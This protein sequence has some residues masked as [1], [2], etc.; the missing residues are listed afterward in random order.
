MKNDFYKRFEDR[1]R[2][3]RET[4]KGRLRV[5]LPLVETLKTLMPVPSALDL[6]CGR[7]EWLE[8]LGEEGFEARGIDQDPQ[9]LLDAHDLGL[10][11][12]QGDALEHLRNLPEASV[13]LV[14]GFHIAEHLLFDDLLVLVEQAHRVLIPGGLLI[15]ETPNPENIA[16]GANSFY[17]DPTHTRPLP[18]ALLSFLPEFVG[19]ERGTIFRLNAREFPPET[20]VSLFD[21]I[22]GASPDYALVAQKQ[23][24]PEL[25]APFDAEFGAHHGV[26]MDELALRSGE[27]VASA[28]ATILHLFDKID[29]KERMIAELNNRHGNRLDALEYRLDALEHRFGE[30]TTELANA[31]AS[32]SWKITRPLR[33]GTA[34]LREAK[35]GARSSRARFKARL[36]Q[37]LSQALRRSVRWVRTHPRAHE[38]ATRL[39]D[40][41]PAV[42]VSI[43]KR[44]YDSPAPSA[45]LSHHGLPLSPRATRILQDL[46]RA[47]HQAPT[48]EQ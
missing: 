40:R 10:N 21:V 6:G 45:P 8:L 2:G 3:S 12:I 13:A 42:V 47:I 28:E 41:F 9:M 32:R 5:Y 23:A 15:L 19:F 27:R 37:T 34:V 43:K 24:Q 30:V 1:F 20:P 17:T 46:Q 22:T 48:G 26:S 44:L 36:G 35:Q 18:P 38:A 4:I 16:V 25:M 14:S 11:V 31:Y 33:W 7:G 39:A 29:D